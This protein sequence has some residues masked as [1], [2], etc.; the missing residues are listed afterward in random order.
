MPVLREL[1]EHP[2][3]V[4]RSLCGVMKDVEFPE[5]EPELPVYRIAH[6]RKAFTFIDTRKNI[7]QRES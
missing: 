7:L 4:D 3:A 5:R 2:E 1:L 6:Y